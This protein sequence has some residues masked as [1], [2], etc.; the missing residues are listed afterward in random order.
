MNINSNEIKVYKRR[1][2]ILFIFSCISFIQS[3]FWI[4]FSGIA[5]ETMSF[6]RTTDFVVNLL[7]AW[8][9]ALCIPFVFVVTWR[10]TT[11]KTSLRDLTLW[12]IMLVALGGF[13]RC[14]S[15]INPKSWW[16]VWVVS[17]G[18]I[19]NA[20]SGPIVLIAPPRL[21]SKWFP[22]EERTLATAISSSS[23]NLGSGVGFLIAP[24]LTDALGIKMYL[25]IEASIGAFIFLVTLVYFPEE[26][27]TPPSI[28]AGITTE[29]DNSADRLT[30]K[31]FGSNFLDVLKHRSYVILVLIGGWQAGVVIAWSGMFDFILKDEFSVLFIGLLGFFFITAST[32]G[33]IIGGLLADKFF[34]KRFKLFMYI[35]FTLLG[36]VLVIF[37]LGFRSFLGDPVIDLPPWLAGLLL[38]LAGIFYGCT[39]PIF[40]ELGV[41]LTYPLN[42][43]YSSGMYTLFADTVTLGTLKFKHR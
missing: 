22:V 15:F 42:E 12:A 30:C 2:Y 6:Y 23:N 19:L 34:Q 24:Y 31:T 36:I 16:A 28:S 9:P 1:W 35:L 3:A 14:L 40:Y 7:L 33:A 17:I 29:D 26:P 37:T 21:S 5:Q 25:I 43:S 20:I 39:I 41:E 38:V 27:P 13:I 4:T 8:G 18:Q 32:F 10:F 11:S